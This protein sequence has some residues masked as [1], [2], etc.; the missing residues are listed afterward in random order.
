MGSSDRT[1]IDSNLIS[2]VNIEK[3][4]SAKASPFGSG[5]IGG[6]VNIRTL[7]TQDILQDGQNLAL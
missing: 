6:T 4:A 7:G 2:S 1:Y 3:G 5:A